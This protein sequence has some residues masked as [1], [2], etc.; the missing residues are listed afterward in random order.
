M[1]SPGPRGPEGRREQRAGRTRDEVKIRRLWST[2]VLV[3]GLVF[4]VG[5]ACGGG[6]DDAP[7]GDGGKVSGEDTAAND[8]ADASDT[9]AD[10]TN[11]ASTT[12]ADEGQAGDAIGDFAGKD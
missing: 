1:D 2:R 10:F 12:D 4:A 6:G 8:H 9:P 7:D 11:D 3:M 5:S